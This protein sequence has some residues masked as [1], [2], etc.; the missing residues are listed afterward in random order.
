MWLFPNIVV[1]VE[2]RVKR[3]VIQTATLS[4]GLGTDDIKI[5]FGLSRL[6][7]FVAVSIRIDCI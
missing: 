3:Q 5:G 6:T 2:T 4:T 1:H 7:S